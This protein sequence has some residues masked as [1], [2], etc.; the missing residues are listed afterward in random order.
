MRIH[1]SIERNGLPTVKLLWPVAEDEN[2]KKSIVSRLLAK[3]DETIPLETEDFAL[4]DYILLV[5]G[6]ECLHYQ[7]LSDVLKDED[8]ITL[9]LPI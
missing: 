6:S 9:V 8:H 7:N 2:G 4:E 3:V 5:D 1:L